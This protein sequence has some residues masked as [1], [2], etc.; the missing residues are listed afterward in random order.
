MRIEPDLDR[1]R[2]I[3]LLRDRY[4]LEAS[5]LTFVPSGIDSWSY[6]ATCRGGSQAFVKLSR[7]ATSTRSDLRLL[8]ALAAMNVAV[9]RPFVDRDGGLV[10]PFDGYD[11]QV[12]EYLD[13]HDL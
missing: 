4:L 13:G 10:N 1:A 6:V 9:P 2:L 3:D 11:V 5:R 7:K 8:A 12:L